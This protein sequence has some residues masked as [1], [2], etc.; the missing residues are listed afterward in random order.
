MLPYPFIYTSS[1][2]YMYVFLLLFA[3]EQDGWI[4]GNAYIQH[5]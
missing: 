2:E 5:L 4:L 1:S 3:E